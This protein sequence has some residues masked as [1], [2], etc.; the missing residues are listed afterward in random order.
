MIEFNTD[1]GCIAAHGGG[2]PFMENAVHFSTTR[3]FICVDKCGTRT[4]NSSLK[5][6]LQLLD[7]SAKE[8]HLELRNHRLIGATCMAPLTVTL[9][10][11]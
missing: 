1:I 6:R 9:P 5:I 2:L 8:V 7:H 11:S 3:Q 4:F 10:L